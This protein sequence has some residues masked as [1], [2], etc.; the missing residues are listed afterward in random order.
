[1]LIWDYRVIA[2]YTIE[3][4]PF[5][6]EH[7]FCM[8]SMLPAMKGVT[9]EML[10]HVLEEMKQ[11]Y[12]TKEMEQ[13]LTLFWRM[14]QKSRT[15]T[16]QEK[17]QVEEVIEMEFDWWIDTNPKIKKRVAKGKEEGALEEARK[18][19]LEVAQ[20][21][22]P[23]QLPLAQQHIAMVTNPVQLR[24]LVIDLFQAPDETAAM[25]LLTDNKP[26]RSPKRKKQQA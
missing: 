24:K 19:V 25:L 20:N 22:F 23:A 12:S 16:K 3:A 14:L 18:M 13:H 8:Y 1:L 15:L 4:E 9:V 2:L 21:R 7:A 6:R 10:V 5:V 26:K 17:E 11:H